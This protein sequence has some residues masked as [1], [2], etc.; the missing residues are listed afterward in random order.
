[1]TSSLH[2]DFFEQNAEKHVPSYSSRE[3]TR[4]CEDP[5]NIIQHNGEGCATQAVEGCDQ[6]S[7]LLEKGFSVSQA[8]LSM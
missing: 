2:Q 1:M 7:G 5:E 6:P 8:G 4:F 3:C